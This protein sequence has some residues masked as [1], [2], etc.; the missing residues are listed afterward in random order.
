MH[1]FRVVSIRRESLDQLMTRPEYASVELIK[2]G[3]L[4]PDLATFLN[5][6][7]KNPRVREMH[8]VRMA[9]EHLATIEKPD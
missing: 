5:L 6:L 4:W 7:R 8:P 1:W 2:E 9:F 3:D